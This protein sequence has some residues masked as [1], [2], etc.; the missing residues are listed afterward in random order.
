[1]GGMSKTFPS[2]FRLSKTRIGG[3][4]AHES[5]FNFAGTKAYLDL[6]GPTPPSIF[7]YSYT[8]RPAP[9]P[10]P[11]LAPTPKRII[12]HGPATIVWWSDGTKTVVKRHSEEDDPEKALAMALARRVWGRSRT[13]RYVKSIERGDA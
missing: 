4:V 1:M 6:D 13:A 2:P 9:I 12:A 11:R 7:G 8:S 3:T 5:I 10:K